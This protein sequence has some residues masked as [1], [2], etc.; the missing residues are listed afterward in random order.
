MSLYFNG[1]HTSKDG[2]NGENQ[3]T[4]INQPPSSSQD[5]TEKQGRLEVRMSLLQ[6]LLNTVG[7]CAVLLQQIMK[8]MMITDIDCN[9]KSTPSIAT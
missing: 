7:V 8:A 6:I 9:K 4:E 2:Q 5:T 3:N 1:E